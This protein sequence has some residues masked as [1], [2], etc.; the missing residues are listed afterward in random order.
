MQTRDLDRIHFIT[1]HFN[2]LQGLR[3]CVPMGLL[4]LSV[5]G[6][7]YFANPSWVL[8]RAV[9]FL[10][11]FLLAFGAKKYY[12]RTFGEVERQPVQP[13]A[14]LS[15]I[16]IYSP[17]GPISRLTDSQGISLS[18]QRFFITTGLA[19]TLF[20]I[21][22]AISPS[23]LINTD[24]S[25]VQ[26]PWRTLNSILFFEL[27]GAPDM[28]WGSGSTVKAV[29]GQM[30]YVALRRF[31]PGRLALEGTASVPESPL[32]AGYRAA[33][34]FSPRYLPGIPRAG[35][36]GDRSDSRALRAGGRPS[37]GGSAPV[38]LLDDPGWPARS[39]ATRP[40]TGTAG[41]RIDHGTPLPSSSSRTWTGGSTIPR[42]WPS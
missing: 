35:S 9:L 13:I 17:A 39:L 5:G 32:G 21:L 27:S 38:W 20:V 30:M 11:A 36:W 10:G 7:T 34:A 42:G 26:Q 40:D 25:L 41:W 24:E 33:G 6:T 31:L 14:K 4:T 18:V 1:R 28:V 16:S 12:Q 19:L 37:L 23:V 8:L 2:D 22:Q 15:S 3:Y 29:F